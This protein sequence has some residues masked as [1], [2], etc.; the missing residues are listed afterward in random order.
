MLQGEHSAIFL[1]YIKLPFV[2]KIF[3][4]SIFEWP[5]YTGFTVCAKSAD[6]ISINVH[7]RL[8]NHRIWQT[9]L[10]LLENGLSQ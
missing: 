1:T 7:F 8:V 2:I 9:F 5:F 4:L 6:T 3:V 10:E